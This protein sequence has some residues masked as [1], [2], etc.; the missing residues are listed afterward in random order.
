MLI[1]GRHVELSLPDIPSMA[2]M[3]NTYRGGRG[4][5]M[6]MDGN[7]RVMCVDKKRLFLVSVGAPQAYAVT[8]LF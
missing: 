7:G 6:S 4:S 1:V 3:D 5:G 8:K 2:S